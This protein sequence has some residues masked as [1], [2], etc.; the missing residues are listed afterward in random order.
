LIRSEASCYRD[1]VSSRALGVSVALLLLRASHGLA[2]CGDNVDDF[3]RVTA[4]RAQIASTCNC[5]GERRA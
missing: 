2:A 3:E 4:V 5:N 1:R